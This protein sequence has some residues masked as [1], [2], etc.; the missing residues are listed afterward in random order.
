MKDYLAELFEPLDILAKKVTRKIAN[1]A[2]LIIVCGLFFIMIAIAYNIMLRGSLPSRGAVAEAK[3]D[4][5]DDTE[6]PAESAK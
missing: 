5:V 2:V 1:E 6:L 4:I 3:E